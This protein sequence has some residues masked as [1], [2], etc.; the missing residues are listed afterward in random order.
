M[1]G[2]SSIFKDIANSTRIDLRLPVVS[3]SS[4]GRHHCTFDVPS[5][6]AARELGPGGGDLA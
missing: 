4:S 1:T 5:F 6:L 2:T 3:I